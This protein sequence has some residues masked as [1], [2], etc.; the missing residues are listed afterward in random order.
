MNSYEEKIGPTVHVP[1]S[2]LVCTRCKY[3]RSRLQMSGRNPIYDYYCEHPVMKEPHKVSEELIRKLKQLGK[4]SA[5]PAFEKSQ[6][7][8]NTERA[9]RG[10]FIG[11]DSQTPQWCPVMGER[12]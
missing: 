8:T 5:I 3:L 12:K 7:R 6:L 10:T 4:E 2:E 1:R 9:E 11:N